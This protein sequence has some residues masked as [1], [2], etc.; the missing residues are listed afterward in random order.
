MDR[1]PAPQPPS[2][3]GAA[4]TNLWWARAQ[5]MVLSVHKGVG[6]PMGA[7]QLRLAGARSTFEE[8]VMAAHPNVHPRRAYLCLHKACVPPV[9]VFLQPGDAEPP[10]CPDGHGR[11]TLQAN[12]PYTRPD[13][14]KP[15]GKPQAV[16]KPKRR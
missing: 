15:V 4:R 14:S 10:H 2:D 6:T 5:C 11:M 1:S 3:K 7:R 12:L 9:R 8:E 13:T 16:D